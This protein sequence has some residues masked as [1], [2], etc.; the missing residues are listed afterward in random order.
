[1][2]AHFLDSCA[3]QHRYIDS[4]YSRRVRGL[5][6]RKACECFI[7]EWSV[8]EMSSAFANRLRKN[9]LTVVEF[10]LLNNR[11]LKDIAEGRLKVINMTSRDFIKARNLIRYAG[12]VKKKKSQKWRCYGSDVLSCFSPGP[13]REGKFLHFRLDAVRRLTKVECIFRPAR[14]GVAGSAESG[15]IIRDPDGGYHGGKSLYCISSFLRASA[16]SV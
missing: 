3:L 5:V 7:S 10:D 6:T 9:S 15:I 16:I 12:V 13:K 11:F 2:P 8:L 14:F 4:P 1:M